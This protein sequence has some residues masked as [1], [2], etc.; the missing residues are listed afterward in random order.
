MYKV[1]AIALVATAQAAKVNVEREPLLTWK[2]K[3]PKSHPVDYVV[4]NFGLDHDIIA[5]QN[6]IKLEE[7]RLGHEWKATLKK[8][9]AKPHPQNYFVPNFGLDHNIVASLDNLKTAEKKYGTWDLPKEDVQL[10]ADLDRE[11]L[12]SW[13]PKAPKTHPIDYFVPNFG[14]DHEIVTTQDNI[15]AQEKLHPLFFKK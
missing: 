14:L 1:G 6:N 9:L 10:E 12:L 2:P 13:K 3:A 11:P 5:A 7:N 8:D 15:A 4:P